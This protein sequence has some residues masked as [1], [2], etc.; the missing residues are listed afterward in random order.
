MLNYSQEDSTI[1]ESL[2]T[3]TETQNDGHTESPIS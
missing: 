1:P 2:C 3:H